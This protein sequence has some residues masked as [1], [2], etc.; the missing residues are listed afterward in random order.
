MENGGDGLFVLNMRSHHHD[1][2]R[3]QMGKA[4]E[5][6]E[7]GQRLIGAHAGFGSFFSQVEFSQ[8][9]D[10]AFDAGRFFLN[11]FGQG[12]RIQRMNPAQPGQHGANL[13]AL[14]MTDEAPA[15]IGGQLRCFFQQFLS[16]VFAEIPDAEIVISLNLPD[17]AMFGND[18]NPAIRRT[19]RTDAVI[20]F[21]HGIPLFTIFIIARCGMRKGEL[22]KADLH[23]HTSASF[24]GTQPPQDILRQARQRQLQMIAVADHNETAG[25]LQ[26]QQ[27]AQ[28]EPVEVLSGI[29]IDCFFD[30]NVVHLLGYGCD[31]THP[32]FARLAEHYRSE[33]KRVGERRLALVEEHYGVR[34]D[35]QR[36]EQLAQGRPFT[37]VEI[38]RVLLESAHHPQLQVYQNGELSGNPIAAF[39]WDQ[40]AIGKWGYV[41]MKLPQSEQ[42]IRW[43]HQRGG[44]VIVAHPLV[45]LGL[46]LQPAQRLMQMGADGFEVYSSYHDQK[47]RQVYEQFC[48]RHDLISTFGS[49]YHGATKPNIALGDTGFEGDCTAS[50]AQLKERIR[51]WQQR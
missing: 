31:L 51:Y 49:D 50:I 25:A 45:T 43:I 35:R 7:E 32:D 5:L 22:M 40:L 34:L 16:A 6:T 11:D 10:G 1:A 36:I 27:L 23:I 8:Y 26:L 44:A 33:L 15:D 39:Y 46:D 29:E 18:Q 3:D 9:L 4:A 20:D 24:D 2:A 17:A 12:Q 48:R 37:N 41:E 14:Q 42:V 28:T 47:A 21:C 30:D 19:L 13:V 38:T